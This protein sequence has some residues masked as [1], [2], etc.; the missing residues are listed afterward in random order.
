MAKQA[1]SGIIHD[2]DEKNNSSNDESLFRK[3]RAAEPS[4]IAVGIGIGFVSQNRG[5]GGSGT[6]GMLKLGSFRKIWDM[7]KPARRQ[8]YM[9][10]GFV[11][12]KCGL[13]GR[14]ACW[15]WVRFAL[16]VLPQVRRG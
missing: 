3:M 6:L 15:N 12:Q 5:V 1:Q 8:R 11:S 13:A 4:E 9:E 16:F 14:L 10:I 7:G 2:C